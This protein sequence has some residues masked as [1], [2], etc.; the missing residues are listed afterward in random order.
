MARD[1]VRR[2][3]FLE[4]GLQRDD[5]GDGFGLQ[6]GGVDADVADGGGGAV[7]GFKLWGASASAVCLG[8]GVCELA[9][10]NRVSR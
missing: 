6:I 7:D 8:K 5:D 2:S 3:E 10:G 1:V 4:R 9:I